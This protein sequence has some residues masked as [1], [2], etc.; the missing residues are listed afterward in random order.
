MLT[1]APDWLG[2]VIVAV[3][4]TATV[5]AGGMR[6]ITFVQAFQYWLKLTALL[7]PA[8]FLVL[9]WQSD[10]EPPATPST[11]RPPS[12]SSASSASATASTLKLDR[13][14]TVTV[15]GT[16]DGRTHTGT[17]LDLPAGTHRVERGTRLTFAEGAAVPEAQRSGGGD[18]SPCTGR[19]AR[20]ARCTPR[21]G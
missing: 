3:V 8:L 17:R 1:G 19:A 14:L 16:V 20:N 2:G 13:P 6:S 11:S 21:T 15:T 12:V 18:L 9:A 7:V 10:S 5:A 4:V